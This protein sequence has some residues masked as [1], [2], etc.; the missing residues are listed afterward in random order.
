MRRMELIQ[1]GGT[2]YMNN[3]ASTLAY[4]AQRGQEIYEGEIAQQL[5]KDCQRLW[6]F[7]VRRPKKIIGL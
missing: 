3:F 6:L 7:N 1:P 2:L 5:V 4:L